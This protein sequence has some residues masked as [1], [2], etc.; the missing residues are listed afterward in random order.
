MKRKI[1]WTINS[2]QATKLKVD[3]LILADGPISSVFAYTY[4]LNQHNSSIIGLTATKSEKNVYETNKIS[5]ESKDSSKLRS[6]FIY[7]IEKLNGKSVIVCQLYNQLK[8]NEL[9][10]WINQVSLI[11]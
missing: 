3:E 9:Y 6:N 8:P 11:K 7:H 10:D 4:L 2:S 1:Y 5:I